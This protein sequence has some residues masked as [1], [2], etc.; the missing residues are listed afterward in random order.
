[1]RAKLAHIKSSLSNINRVDRESVATEAKKVHQSMKDITSQC[2]SKLICEVT[3]ALL[4]KTLPTE[5]AA[6]I[7]NIVEQ[8]NGKKGDSSSFATFY[9]LLAEQNYRPCYWRAASDELNYR[10]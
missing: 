1:M 10:Y 9:K 2:N 8:I 7:K 4:L 5:A 3:D 6:T